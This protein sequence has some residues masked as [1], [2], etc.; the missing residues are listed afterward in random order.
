AL[1]AVR[2]AYAEHIP[3][4]NQITLQPENHFALPN[5][6]PSSDIKFQDWLAFKNSLPL[7]HFTV[8]SGS[9]YYRRDILR[10][11]GTLEAA[12]AAWGTH[13]RQMSELRFPPDV[14]TGE[15]AGDWSDFVRYRLPRRLLQVDA[16]RYQA[17]FQRY[18]S[19]QFGD[20]AALNRR[21][22]TDF[23]KLSDLQLT[24][25][26]PKDERLV[27]LWGNFLADRI[28]DS[29]K[30]LL[31]PELEF[32]RFLKN[33]YRDLTGLNRVW[34][35]NFQDWKEVELPVAESDYLNYIENQRH[36]DSGF[37]TRNFHRVL[38]YLTG[39]GR[40]LLN[41]LILVVL[42]LATALTVNPLAAYAL[43]RFKLKRGYVV[44]IFLLVTM[45]FPAEVTMI[46]GFLL[47]RDL[48]LLNTFA[49]LV[50]PSVANGYS[51]FLL[52]GFFDSLPPE[53]YEAATIDGAS[54]MVIFRRVT[55]PLSKPILA[56]IALNAFVSAYGGFMWAFLVCQD[57]SMWTLMVFLY[58]FQWQHASE[59]YLAMTALVIA[60]V[61]TM[62]VFIFCQKIIMRGIVVPTE[63]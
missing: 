49:A 47:L 27:V 41:T 42:A 19:K 40:A 18:L 54:E 46:P 7:S 16:E 29:E 24:S 63:K 14:L 36:Y 21:Y 45:A 23:T 34:K 3:Q 52:K 39:K 55:M 50:L 56:V 10:R 28:P 57:E 12:N 60:S 9:W 38:Y 43:S 33:E 61:P 62:L 8:I 58:Q 2:H 30:K 35:T 17:E 53:L 25:G 22:G 31:A 6:I 1:T 20:A 26:V 37:L 5:W 51:V 4:F 11:H 44:M 48:D 13:Y 59:P 15:Q 32:H